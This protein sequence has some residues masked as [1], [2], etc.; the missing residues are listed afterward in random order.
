[1]G[2]ISNAALTPPF[3]MFPWAPNYILPS[4]STQRGEGRD[5]EKVVA[6]GGWKTGFWGSRKWLGVL[7]VA[8]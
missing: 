1:V 4:K 6:G 3:F 8:M 5:E 2:S 7:T